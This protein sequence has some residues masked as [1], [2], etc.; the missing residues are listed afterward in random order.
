[1]KNISYNIFYYTII[2][3]C[4]AI[5]HSNTSLGQSYSSVDR[6]KLPF[7]MCGKYEID[8]ILV[9]P[10]IYTWDGKTIEAKFQAND[11]TLL[12][13]YFKRAYTINDYSTIYVQDTVIFYTSHKLAHRQIEAIVGTNT[14]KLMPHTVKHSQSNLGYMTFKVPMVVLPT[15][16]LVTAYLK[17]PEMELTIEADFRYKQTG[18]EH[19]VI[20]KAHMTDRVEY[21]DH[22]KYA[23]IRRVK[24]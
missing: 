15:N 8:S 7:F 11:T 6:T 12:G 21:E 14:G 17:F 22:E 4:Y 16:Q 18:S 24:H 2:L 3:L 19:K 13:Q 10:H 1:M 9:T 23:P 5:I 20:I